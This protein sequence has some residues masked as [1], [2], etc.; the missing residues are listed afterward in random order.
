MGK[1]RVERRIEE[2]LKGAGAVPEPV[3]GHLKYRL[4]GGGCVVLS[5]TP[6]DP[7]TSMNQLKQVERRLGVKV[8]A[9][10]KG[11]KRHRSGERSGLMD[12]L[13]SAGLS[14]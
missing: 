9:K 8:T 7:R 5:A 14:A 13:L 12:R 2:L 1:D 10:R 6:G 11:A 4:P 3:N